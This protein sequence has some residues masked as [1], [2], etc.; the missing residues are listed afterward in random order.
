MP[1][2]PATRA[3]CTLLTACA[4]LGPLAPPAA[5]QTV[6]SVGIRALGMGGAFVAVAD[7]A[8]ATWW[9][10]GALA[11]GPFFDASAGMTFDSSSPDARGRTGWF[12]ASIP[13]LGLSNYRLRMSSFGTFD[14]IEGGPGNREEG[15]EAVPVRYWQVSQWSATFVQTLLTGVHAGTTLKYLRGTVRQGL[16]GAG[17]DDDALLDAAGDLSGGE[18]DGRFDL[19]VGVLATGGPVRVGVL[20]KNLREPDF[21]PAGPQ[22]PRQVRIGAAVD[23]AAAGGPALVVSV[24]ADA[25]TYATA[26]GERRVVA[27][28]AEQW[29]AGRRVGVRGGIRQNRAGRR[30]RVYTAGASVRLSRSSFVDGFVAGGD[31]DGQAWGLALRVSY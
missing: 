18:R 27:A 10:P 7:D 20:V 29:L 26:S 3:A 23:A 14:P 15:G 22:L 1:T 24:D 16:A 21:G 11:A 12:T 2:V 17:L 25:R 13:A 30:E 8:T 28:G 5:A 9:N 31:T 19:D 4:L 6:E